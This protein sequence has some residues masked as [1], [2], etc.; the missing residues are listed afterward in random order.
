MEKEKMRKNKSKTKVEKPVYSSDLKIVVIGNVNTGKTSLVNRYIHDKFV[1][2]YK[3]TLG[4]QFDYKIIQLNET[5]YRIH[6]WDLG[7]QDRNP[8]V[9]NL[10]ARDSNGVIIVCEA[11]EEQSMKDTL[12]WKE[13]VI[14]NNGDKNISIILL[15]NKSDLIEGGD[16]AGIKK[17][18]T[19]AQENGYD[20]AFRT[21]AKTGY[22]VDKA[23]LFLF[24][25]IIERKGNEPTLLTDE[26]SLS[27]LENEKKKNENCCKN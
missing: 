15:E 3:P 13:N 6:F 18:E 2:T 1:S 23:L 8:Q 14:E 9:T 25:L 10:F 17:L 20:K 4:S 21:S 11:N 24:N 27:Y 7:G 16:E 12:A 19:F 26:E 22:G 5:I